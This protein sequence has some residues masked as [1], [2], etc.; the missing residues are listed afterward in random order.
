MLY[1]FVPTGLSPPVPV[2]TGPSLSPEREP[3]VLLHVEGS[4]PAS[5]AFHRKVLNQTAS[6]LTNRCMKRITLVL[7]GSLTMATGAMAQ[8]LSPSVLAVSGGSA[9]TATMM[10]DWTVGEAVTGTERTAGQLY[11]QG[12]HQ[13]L[14]QIT[15]QQNLTSPDAQYQFTVAPNPVAD[16]ISVSVSTPEP[17]PLFLTLTDLTGRR[18]NLPVIPASAT[19]AQVDMTVYPAG[20]Y[21]LHIAK[22]EGVPLK[23]YKIIKI[24]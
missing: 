9:R 6:T 20:M 4:K 21:L 8:R 16:W 18:Y 19:S 22:K 2:Y 15:E 1:L 3:T 5:A 10:L 17:M 14:L 7:F 24:Q 11:T 12:F 13:P 23:T